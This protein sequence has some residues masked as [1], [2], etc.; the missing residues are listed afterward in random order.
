MT[1][2]A[3]TPSLMPELSRDLP[4]ASGA[5]TT[6]YRRRT[7]WFSRT[8]A[9]RER[10]SWLTPSWG[11]PPALGAHVADE[12][13]LCELQ[14][15]GRDP[16]ANPVDRRGLRT[17][18]RIS[19]TTHRS[20]DRAI[21]IDDWRSCTRSGALK[22]GV[23]AFGKRAVT[24][25]RPEWGH[26]GVQAGLPAHRYQLLGRACPSRIGRTAVRRASPLRPAVACRR[27]AAFRPGLRPRA[28]SPARVRD[29]AL[30][31]TLT[32]SV[33]NVVLP[34][35]ARSATGSACR[36]DDGRCGPSPSTA[37]VDRQW[38]AVPVPGS[39]VGRGCPPDRSV[40][41]AA[42]STPQPDWLAAISPA[43]RAG[44]HPRRR[45][46]RTKNRVH[47][48]RRLADEAGPRRGDD[49]TAEYH[50]RSPVLRT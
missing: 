21:A 27:P 50:R 15:R 26:R 41:S 14:R 5:R 1:A 49:A 32:R 16:S 12:C 38:H 35:S 33:E 43:H 20:S 24:R 4:F 11:T 40:H 8:G 28:V 44:D 47:R 37:D 25:C 39:G 7:A 31:A 6:V 9:Q 19:C 45:N 34:R 23:G 22:R 48:R 17:K 46:R 2:T 3:T 30:N 13:P 36:T 18:L 29:A 42:D 10:L